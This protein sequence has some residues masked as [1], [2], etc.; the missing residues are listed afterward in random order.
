MKKLVL[1]DAMAILHRAYHALPPLTTRAGEPI[2]AIYGLTGMLL[3]IIQDLTP[4]HIAFCFDEEAPTFRRKEF[5]DYQ[6][7]RAPVADE[8]SSQFKKARD[9]AKATGIP[10]YSM[11]GYEADDIIGTI[12]LGAADKKLFD[13]VVIV[14]GDRDILQL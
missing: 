3:R 9:F 12:S 1:I 10:V 14:T 13:E 5:K 6:V 2:G 4:T 7:Q 8:L 11:P